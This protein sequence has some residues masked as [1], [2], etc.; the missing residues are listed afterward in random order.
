MTNHERSCAVPG[1]DRDYL[2]KGLCRLHWERQHRTGTTDD[3]EPRSGPLNAAWKGDD[4][5]YAAAHL[6]MSRQPRPP[7]CEQCGTTDGRFEWAL[8]PDVPAGSLLRSSKGYRY[9]TDPSHYANLCKACH[10]NLDL[11][12]DACH[13]GHPLTGDNVYVQPSNGK[14][15]CRKC[16]ARRRAERSA[17]ERSVRS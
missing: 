1:C 7:A 3:P 14:R 9:S 5:G 4:A 8:K 16:Q 6:R 11:S 10:N 15:F 17:R 13:K 2:C 12:G